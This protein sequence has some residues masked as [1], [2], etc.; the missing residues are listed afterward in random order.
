VIDR[1]RRFVCVRRDLRRRRG[2]LRLVRV[3]VGFG[4]AD[5]RTA[6]TYTSQIA[7]IRAELPCAAARL[8]AQ[9][10]AGSVRFQNPFSV[11][12]IRRR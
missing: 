1:A 8:R 7:A 11:T 5:G 3:P 2:T 12:A 4:A 6:A 9:I 10:R